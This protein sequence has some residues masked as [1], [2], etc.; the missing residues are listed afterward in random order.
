M[1]TVE[2]DNETLKHIPELQAA[3]VTEKN[4]H[5]RSHDTGILL[6]HSISE[7]K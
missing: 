1:V 2:T 4:I 3:F 6:L 7:I 5:L